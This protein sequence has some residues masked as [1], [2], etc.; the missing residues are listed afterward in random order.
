MIFLIGLPTMKN[1]TTLQKKQE[2]IQSPYDSGILLPQEIS[3]LQGSLQE[4]NNDD[5]DAR[6]KVSGIDLRTRLYNSEI[7]AILV[8]DTLVSFN[9]LPTTIAPLTISKKR[10]NVSRDGLGRK[11]IVDIVQ[12]KRDMDTE[13]QSFGSKLKGLFKKEV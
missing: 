13:R 2:E 11:E 4:L 8:I 5:F 9:F 1:N 12:G 10:L 7:T 6:R 3:E